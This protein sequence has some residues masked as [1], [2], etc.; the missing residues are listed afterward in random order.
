MSFREQNPAIHAQNACKVTCWIYNPFFAPAA[1]NLTQDGLMRYNSDGAAGVFLA[2]GASIKR[3]ISFS[4][5]ANARLR[6][7]VVSY[8]S[9]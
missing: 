9:A 7:P 6:L 8:N 4:N 3:E 5:G 2:R 1:R